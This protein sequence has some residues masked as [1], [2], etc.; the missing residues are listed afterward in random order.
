M[1]N[2]EMKKTQGSINISHDVECPHCNY[3]H[4]DYHDKE[5]WEENITDQMPSEEAYKDNYK[6]VCKECKLEFIVDG[7]I[8]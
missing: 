3:V 6:A 2:E 1:S 5:W 7:F 8:Y 4:D